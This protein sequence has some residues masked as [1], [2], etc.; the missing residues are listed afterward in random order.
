MPDNQVLRLIDSLTRDYDG[1]AKKL[2]S[3]IEKNVSKGMSPEKAARR[4]FQQLGVDQII[5]KK[6]EESVVAAAQIGYMGIIADSRAIKGEL[7]SH[8][9]PGDALTLSER[10]NNL[11]LLPAIQKEIYI[12]MDKAKTYREL[13]TT[14]QEK[15]LTY[16]DFPQY[17]DKLISKAKIYAPDAP[18]LRKELLRVKG[19]INQLSRAGAPTTN[20]KAGYNQVIEAIEKG[21]AKQLEKAIQWAVNEKARYNAMRIGRT[22][23]AR[24]HGLLHDKRAQENP[25]VVGV[26]Y[27]LSSRHKEYDI[28]DL[29]CGV[30]AFGMGPGVYP[31]MFHPPFPFHP[32]CLCN[33]SFVYRTE[34]PADADF[35]PQKVGEWLKKQSP[36]ELQKLMGKPGA[37]MF[38]DKPRLWAKAVKGYQGNAKPEFGRLKGPL[39]KK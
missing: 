28:C 23:I 17:M 1:L 29:H 36:E 15:G 25:R 32:H 33:P 20:L 27:S 18:E 21:N 22:E 4:A 30:D 24:A 11:P 12:A 38:H 39:G 8:H 34:A 19:R 10:L 16:A 7:L 6:I 14:L 3:Q 37:E 26:K 13:A 5:R 35:Q 31:K 2:V 9:W